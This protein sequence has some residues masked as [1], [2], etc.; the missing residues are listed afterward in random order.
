[1]LERKKEYTVSALNVRDFAMV[2]SKKYKVLQ[3]EVGGKRLLYHYYADQDAQA[4][5]DAVKEA[6]AY[7]EKAFGKYPYSTY[8]LA[9]TSLCFDGMEYPCLAMLSD[10]L[11]GVERIR[12]AVHETAHQWW[13]AA[14]GSDSVENAWQDE[15]LAE[16]SALLFFDAHEKYG[17]TRDALVAECLREY[18]SYYDV[19]GS[20]LGRTE[21]RMTRHLKEFISDYEYRCLSYDKAVIMFD[22]L[23]KSVGDKKFFAGLK[24]YYSENLYSN[25][26]VGSLIGGFERCGVD[27]HGFFDGFLSGKGVL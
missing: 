17:L 27:A 16:Y 7:F 20:V 26:T 6:F 21:T 10:G 25:A 3:T 5:L 11:T 2:L 19:Y 12:A 23:R 15:G 14:V 1:M 18:R 8:T 13:Y 22:T 24:K 4:T 9:E